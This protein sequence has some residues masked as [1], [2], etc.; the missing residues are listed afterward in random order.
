MALEVCE[1]KACLDSSTREIEEKMRALEEKNNYI[2]QLK[3]SM[4][5]NDKTLQL[6]ARLSTVSTESL[7]I[8]F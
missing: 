3:Q 4:E 1:L 2:S 8:I 6:E 5:E 7:A